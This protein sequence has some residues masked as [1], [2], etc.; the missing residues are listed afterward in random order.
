MMS[1][2]SARPHSVA[3]LVYTHTIDEYAWHNGHADL[4]R[5][6]IDGQQGS[7]YPGQVTLMSEEN[8]G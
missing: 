6:R 4:L 2:P 5:Q 8:L 7:W 3:A 1:S